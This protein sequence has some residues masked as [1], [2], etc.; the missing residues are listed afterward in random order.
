MP[1]W[2]VGRLPGS[3]LPT[4][5][6]TGVRGYGDAPS[7]GGSSHT[8][9]RRSPPVSA[10]LRRSAESRSTMTG[11]HALARTGRLFG[12][13]APGLVAACPLRPV[14]VPATRQ[15]YGVFT[16]GGSVSVNAHGRNVDTGV[17]A[18]TVLSMRVMLADGSLVSDL[19]RPLRH[20]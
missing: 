1:F 9:L 5:A 2:I 17:L 16:V 10:G 4:R 13:F 3:F 7:D 6:G 18:A 15:S 11:V 20:R 14:Y 8:G 12:Y 19:D